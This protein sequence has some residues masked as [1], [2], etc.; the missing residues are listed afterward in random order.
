[1][2]FSQLLLLTAKI[3][4]AK[5]SRNT[6]NQG[7]AKIFNRE[8]FPSY[9]TRYIEFKRGK[10]GV[11]VPIFMGSPKFYDNGLEVDL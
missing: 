9:G 3:K 8:N 4:I 6:R 7:T 1:M 11:G 5:Y 10:W 2:K